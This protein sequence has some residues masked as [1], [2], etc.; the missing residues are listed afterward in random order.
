MSQG[1]KVY[2]SNSGEVA[3]NIIVVVVR[4]CSPREYP[5]ASRKR[6]NWAIRSN[7]DRWTGCQGNGPSTQGGLTELVR[8]REERELVPEK[9]L[10]T[11]CCLTAEDHRTSICYSSCLRCK[12]KL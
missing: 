7:T 6:D 5:T 11:H 9:L 2:T 12:I 4:S 8:Q 1:D 3:K 10:Q